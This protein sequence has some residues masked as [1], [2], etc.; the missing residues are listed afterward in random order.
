M[1][2]MQEPPSTRTLDADIPEL[3]PYLQPGKKI[4]AVG[5]GVGTIAL[6][7]AEAVK[8]GAVIGIDPNQDNINTARTWAAAHPNINNITFQVGDGHHLEFADNTFD[9]VYSHTVLHFFLD[10]VMGLVEQKRVAKNSGWVIASGIR[11]ARI[12]HPPCPHWE[13]V[14]DAYQQYYDRLVEDYRASGKDPVTFIAELRA[15]NLSYYNMQ[16]GRQCAEWF[17]Q[18]GLT[19]LCFEVQSRRVRYQGHK[20]MK[21]N[22]LDGFCLAKSE[23]WRDVLGDQQY[24][25]MQAY[26]RSFH[27]DMIA[28]GLLDEEML[29][30]AIEEAQ[31]WYKD[32][33]AFQFWP[34]MFAAGR[35]P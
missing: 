34:E 32:P 26:Y 14:L 30:Q 6:D 19:D 25:R 9:L 10:P 18:A 17:H 15:R 4:L 28:T 20:D 1:T 24:Q 13:T 27:Q 16:A 7:V 12:Y 21:P 29:Q 23:G 3:K 33:T 31:V 2:K 5:C 11:D 22:S 8:P 35:V